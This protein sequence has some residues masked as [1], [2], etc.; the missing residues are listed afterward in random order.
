MSLLVLPA[1]WWGFEETSLEETK[2]REHLHGVDY[3][4][5]EL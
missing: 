3:D 4:K 2:D 5:L 1:P